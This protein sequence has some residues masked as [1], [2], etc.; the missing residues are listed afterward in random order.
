VPSSNS[1]LGAIVPRKSPQPSSGTSTTA[2]A[3][4]FDEV[5]RGLIADLSELDASVV[6]IDAALSLAF[7]VLRVFE[8]QL[9][10]RL[11]SDGGGAA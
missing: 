1:N 10:D 5:M 8:R 3:S 2:S 4:I 7:R 11:H 9:L 6:E